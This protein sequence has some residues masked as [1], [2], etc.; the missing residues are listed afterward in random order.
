M[1]LRRYSYFL[2]QVGLVSYLL[3]S[4]FYYFGRKTSV[5]KNAITSIANATY[6][7]LKTTE[8]G[9]SYTVGPPYVSNG[10]TVTLPPASNT[11]ERQKAAF[12][13]LVRNSELQGMLDSMK[14]VEDRFNHK[15]NYP[16]IFLNEERFTEEFI[17]STTKVASSKTHYGFVNES[18]WSYPDWID[19]KKAAI[20]REELSYVPYGTSES[21]R[22]MCRFQSGFFWRHPLVLSLDLEYYWRVEPDVRYYCDL[23]YD[24]FLYMKKH[25]KKY[26]FNISFKEHSGTIASLWETIRS[27]ARDSTRQGK[28]YFPNYATNSLYRFVTDEE[29]SEYNL[30]HFWTNF[31]I[32]RLDLW[33]TEAYQALFEYLDK[34]G[35]FFYER[36]GDAPIHSIF[37]ALY[38][39]KD[40]IHFF[41]DIGYK[42]S[43]Y[44]HCPEQ[45]NLL[46][47]CS[48]DPK[49]TLD[50]TD[51]MSCMY[52]YVA[53]QHYSS[54]E[55][56]QTVNQ[57][58]AS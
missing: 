48:C 58:L 30:C 45:E 32:A 17:K 33:H 35:G 24:P 53:A 1:L 8:S 50:F 6:W 3:G 52:E 36:W 7:E 14:D 18:M 42:H 39:K 20:C 28:N 54:L 51:P 46:R 11:T 38:L 44:E 23:D 41:N 5:Y 27:F 55:N 43:I 34:V 2:L 25:N 57:I 9:E 15:F 29:G 13:V 22:H 37:A 26:A 12:I 49:H 16:W 56:K 40:E 47:R 4:L 31:E 19:Q 21:Y 10:I